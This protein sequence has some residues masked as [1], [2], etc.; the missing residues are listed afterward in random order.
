[1]LLLVSATVAACGGSNETKAVATPPVTGQAVAVIDT[2]RPD[3]FE[4]TG[5]ADPVER[6]TISTRL[7]AT[8]TAV[9]PL[10]GA[11][12]RRGEV[13]VRLDASDLDAKRK[14]VAAGAAEAT[15]MHD[16]AV[17]S[18]SRMKALYADSAAPK[19]QLDAAMAGL[20]RARAGLAAAQAVAAE[21]EASAA[22][23]EVRAP[24]DGIVTHRFVDV[25]AFAAPGAPLLT[26]EASDRLRVSAAIPAA[27]A[28]GMAKGNRIQA[29]LEGVAAEATIEGVVPSGGNLYMVNAIVANGGG[30][31]LAGSSATL[32]VAMGE[33]HVVLVP[34]AALV[35]QGDLVGVRRRMNGTAE[36]TWLRIGGVVGDRT[37]VLSGLSAGDSVLVP[38]PPTGAR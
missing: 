10:E 28:R 31:Y 7:M 14:Q 37:E 4:A 3:Y 18:A 32:L 29:R 1:M 5:V 34:T 16:L 38:V 15:A 11:R 12:V 30:K 19:A 8:V 33:R 27:L 25:G 6:A 17:V 26:V 13:L 9:M 2:V 21:L 23:A 35:R 24:F 20:A 22:Y 36:L